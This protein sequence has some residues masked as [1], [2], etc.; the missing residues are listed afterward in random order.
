MIC[1]EIGLGD[2][3]VAL[4]TFQHQDLG[5][6]HFLRFYSHVFSISAVVIFSNI[7]GTRS[8]KRPLP[9]NTKSFTALLNARGGSTFHIS[10]GLIEKDR[11]AN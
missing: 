7:A 10:Q 3:F 11:I 5:I 9:L 2:R 8:I 6:L 4:F 1:D